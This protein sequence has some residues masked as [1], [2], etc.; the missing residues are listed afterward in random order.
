[1][2]D[3][4][5]HNKSGRKNAQQEQTDHSAGKAFGMYRFG[6]VSVAIGILTATL[7][8]S[9]AAQAASPKTPP[10]STYMVDRPDP[11]VKDRRSAA[12]KRKS[13]QA[14]RQT[15]LVQPKD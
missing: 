2:G 12:E 4:R 1:M 5:F 9:G 6:A 15:A 3:S 10:A 11:A 8:I 7:A 13:A 14:K